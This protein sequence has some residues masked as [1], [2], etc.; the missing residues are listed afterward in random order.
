[1]AN[2]LRRT[3]TSGPRVSPRRRLAGEALPLALL[4]GGAAILAG[5]RLNDIFSLNGDNAWYVNLARDLVTGRPYNN[6]GFPWGYPALLAPGVAL[7]GPANLRAEVPLLKGI[8][9][10]AFLIAAALLYALFR[11]RHSR[12]VAAL[13]VALFVVNDIALVYTNDLMSEMPY[14]A[15]SAAALLYWQTHLAARPLLEGAT[16]DGDAALPARGGGK[17]WV[18]AALLLA[19]PYY[20][21]TIGLAMLAAPPMLLVWQRRWRAALLLGLAL[22]ALAAPWA[23][24]SSLTA[25][26]RN[27]TASLLLRDPYHP[28]LGKIADPGEFLGRFG[29]R[30]A[31]Y[32]GSVLPGMLLPQPDDPTGP[33]RQAGGWLLLAAAVAG[34]IMR[35]V[36]RV[37]LPEVYVAGF[38]VILCSWPWTGDRFLLPVFP[39][40]LHYIAEVLTGLAGLVGRA[41]RR[42]RV[43]APVAVLLLALLMTPNLLQDRQA[44]AR[45][46][47]YL[48]GRSDGGV[49]AEDR[50]YLDACAWLAANTPPD[51][52]VL[53]RKSSVTEL[54]ADRP[55]E[56]IPLIPPE[57]FPDW[58][59]AQGI[60]YVLEDSFPWSNHTV[61]HLR[62]AI[63]LY[64]GHFRL[65]YTIRPPSAELAP[66]RV[67][68]FVP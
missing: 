45:N 9:V 33:V 21:R 36:R 60:A 13:T 55:S 23:V 66:T 57:Q 58:L 19:L 56:L 30:A 32:S 53:S 50:M 54:Y 8:S 15:A 46:L 43:L 12:P 62:P 28:E 61:E 3:L 41:L 1:M 20:V 35:L 17:A 38:V 63:R 52:R 48:S 51:S 26:D 37:E 25:P 49:A 65:L 14:I 24:F 67:W 68:Q 16:G 27:Y 10:L 31:F 29:D 44:V 11:T 18:V 2:T 22:A 64:P 7:F 5:L 34:Y 4:L 47:D 42:P 39:F 40:I 59:R 6:A